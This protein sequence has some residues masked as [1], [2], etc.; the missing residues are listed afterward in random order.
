M[1]LYEYQRRLNELAR[2][3]TDKIYATAVVPAGLTLLATIK[4]RIRRDGK[5]S[6]NQDIGKYSTKPIYAA[7]SQFVKAAAFRAGG[8]KRKDSK[9][10][11]LPAG[12]KQLR[13]IQGMT[14][15][16]MNYDYSG[17]TMADYQHQ[18][19]G[20]ALLLGLISKRSSDIRRGLEKKRGRAFYATSQEMTSYNEDV[21]EIVEDLTVKILKDA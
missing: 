10:M 8:K 14:T 1:T 3:A 21:V 13:D 11:Y 17:S 9:T 7:K 19:T 16:V 4:N 2:A 18:S 20:T 12:Y 5:N 15:S 6:N